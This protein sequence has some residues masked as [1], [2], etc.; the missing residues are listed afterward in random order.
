LMDHLG[1]S[2]SDATWAYTVP[3]SGGKGVRKLT[4]D[5]RTPLDRIRNRAA[6]RR[7]LGWMETSCKMLEID[8]KV[9]KVLHGAVFEVRQGYKSKDSKR[10]NADVANASN[11]YANGYLPVNLT[12]SSQI[13]SN[14]AERYVKA[15]WLLLRGTLDGTSLDSTYVFAREVVGYDLA[16]FFRRNRRKLRT[17]VEGVLKGLLS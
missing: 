14:I 1:L 3:A 7:I 11:A 13:D 16:A 12:L 6:R 9:C 10:Q 15:Q 4:L 5:A 2:D 8:S 17:Q